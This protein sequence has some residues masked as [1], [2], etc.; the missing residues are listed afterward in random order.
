[1]SSATLNRAFGVNRFVQAKSGTN[2]PSLSASFRGAHAPRLPISAPRR[3][4]VLV[5]TKKVVGEAPTTAREARAL[6]RP[7]LLR[8]GK[9]LRNLC[10]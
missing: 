7:Y 4:A 5:Q 3:N 6:P 1:M 2:V 10:Q 9:R 8:P